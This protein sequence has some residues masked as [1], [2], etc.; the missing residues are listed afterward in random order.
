MGHYMTVLK[1]TED[2]YKFPSI[3][4]SVL[5]LVWLKNGIGD[6][7]I[8]IRYSKEED[9]EKL[10]RIA[11]EGTEYE[12]NTANKVLQAFDDSLNDDI[13]LD[14]KLSAGAGGVFLKMLKGILPSKIK[15]D[16]AKPIGHWEV[17]HDHTTV[18][19]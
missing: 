6:F 16:Y 10:R 19:I 3:E 7:Q 1:E 17:K 4:T 2:E 5:P 13:L 11:E 9:A 8:V 15:F 18:P 12:Q 14:I